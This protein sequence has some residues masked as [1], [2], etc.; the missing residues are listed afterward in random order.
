MEL[1]TSNHRPPEAFTNVRNESQYSSR[2]DRL[3]KQSDFEEERRRSNFTPIPESEELRRQAN[4]YPS[5]ARRMSEEHPRSRPDVNNG[6][7]RSKRDR[8]N[9]PT[10]NGK[11]FSKS[12]NDISRVKSSRKNKPENTEGLSQSCHPAIDG[13]FKDNYSF[14]F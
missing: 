14:D 9:E 8:H 7:P 3:A 11:K 13:L 4:V 5:V 1:N 2:H 10:G 12:S 6:R